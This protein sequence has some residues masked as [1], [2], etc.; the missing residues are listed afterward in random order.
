MK[1]KHYFLLSLGIIYFHCQSIAQ[2]D[3]LATKL[4]DLIVEKIIEHATE[5][6]PIDINIIVKNIGT[7]TS[8]PS[9]LTI[10]G[11]YR[12][13]AKSDIKR[14]QL[15]LVKT[16]LS[17]KTYVINYDIPTLQPNE[18]ATFRLKLDKK[19]DEDCSFL[20][21]IDKDNK[22]QESNTKNNKTAYP[23]EALEL[24]NIFP[25][26]TIKK[27][28]QP[29]YNYDNKSTVLLIDIENIGLATAENVTLE[30]WEITAALSDISE[31][32]LRAILGENWWV[33]QERASSE[34][35]FEFSETINELKA[36]EQHRFTIEFSGWIYNPNC[37]I[38]AMVKTTS[39]EDKVGNNASSFIQGG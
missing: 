4:P 17:Y 3:T 20:I 35:M 23:Q 14:L 22:L 27:I 25:D 28:H 19:L 12:S 13:L 31:R 5:N 15:E 36:G 1:I 10:N 18:T 24:F 2:K 30:V 7:A 29:D 9:V 26:L 32:D 21:R 16:D 38:G 34:P 39:E 11:T 33:F 37:K 8:K 6:K